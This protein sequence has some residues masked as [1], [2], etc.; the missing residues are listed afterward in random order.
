MLKMQ[1]H[2][3]PDGGYGWVVV[4][5]SFIAHILEY[6]VVWTV[7]VFYVIFLDHFTESRTLLALIASLNTG[8][9]YL[10]G[11]YFI[12][13]TFG[14]KSSILSLINQIVFQPVT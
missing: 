9:F 12:P 5:A 13:E 10:I 11:Q 7:G 8:S 2:V 3:S 4:C 14:T 6:G 1:M